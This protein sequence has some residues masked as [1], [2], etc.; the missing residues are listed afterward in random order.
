MPT[1]ARAHEAR[2]A[3]LELLSRALADEDVV[4]AA[5][6]AHDRLVK[7]VAGGLDGFALDHAAVETT[8]TSVVPLP[9]MSMTRWPSGLE[10]SAPCTGGGAGGP[11]GVPLARAGL[12]DGV[13]DVALLHAGHTAYGT[14]TS[15]RGLKRLERRH[16]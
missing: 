9:P 2:D 7:G 15:T 3:D 13:D 16:A 6:I 4:L 11:R 5:H 1:S 12:D 10:M 8:A 14:V